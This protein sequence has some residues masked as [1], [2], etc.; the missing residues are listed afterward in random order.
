M[1]AEMWLAAD[2]RQRRNAMPAPTTTLPARDL[3]QLRRS[4]GGD[5]ITPNHAAYDEARRLWNALHDRRPALIL[6]PTDTSEVATAIRFGREHD[7]EVAVRSGGHST[8]GLRRRQ[9]ELVVDLSA[10]RGVAV[11]PDRRVARAN[12]G[13]LLGELDIAAQA[14]GLVCPVGVVGHTGIAGLT[15]GGGVGRL[16]RQFGL[17]IDNLTAVELVTADGRLVGATETE[18]PELF[19]GLRGAGWNFGIA[20]ALAFRLQPFG[21]DLHRGVLAYA[22]SQV[23]D[24]WAV[25]RAYARIAPDAVSVIFGI[26]RARPDSGAL[27]ELVGRPIVTIAFNHSG[28]A[29]AVER[30]TA[31]LLAGPK[32]VATT[33]GSHPYLEVQTAHDLVL[34]WGRR[35]TIMSCNAADLDPALLDELVD[36]VATAP[37]D[38]TFSATALGGAIGRLSEDAT[39]YTGRSAALDMSADIAWEDPALDDANRDWARRVI[40]TVEPHPTLGRYSNGTADAGPEETRA[41]YGDAKLARLAALKRAWDPDNVFHLNY[42]VAPAG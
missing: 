19:W 34:G 5:V 32:P 17:T 30:D 24:A 7:L 27:D 28:A 20:T 2:Q 23:V 14:H 3:D 9:G 1:P 13:A 15:L 36:L 10:M 35:S 29:D 8:D 38:G 4:F 33:L 11:D 42:N 31:A 25:F 41:I 22:P 26:D 12:G 18:E 39:A 21:P 40:A 16:Q 6:R 37:G